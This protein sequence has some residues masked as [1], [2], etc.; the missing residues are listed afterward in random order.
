MADREQDLPREQTTDEVG[1]TAE[2]RPSAGARGWAR[3]SFW[4]LQCLGWAAYFVMVV[5]TFLPMLP[6]GASVWPLVRIKIVRTLIGFTLTSALRLVLRRIGAGR[7]GVAAAVAIP[8]A[9]LLGIV[10]RGL[11]GLV[12]GWQDDLGHIA[13]DW[14]RAPREA[15]DYALTVL[16]WSALYLGV[17]WARDLEA[18][19]AGALEA[20]ALAQQAQLDALRY[21]LNP[22]FLF[23][24]LNAIRALVDEDASR[25]RQMITALSEF[26]RYP[27]LGEHRTAV[28]LRE[29]LAAVRNYL[30]IEA[31]RFDGRLRVAIDADPALDDQLVPALVLHPLV[32][33]AVKHGMMSPGPLSVRVEARQDEA[34][35]V[36]RVTNTGVWRDRGST[37][38]TPGAAVGL[39]NVR[40]RLAALTPRP[41]ALT[42]EHDAG[43]V[44]VAVRLPHDHDAS[45]AGR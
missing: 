45:T 18:A 9:V 16:A 5:A 27:V 17:K 44:N 11:A 24:A 14:A 34:V 20:R 43:C 3:L 6:A 39:R 42:I 23:N 15:L 29:E 28:P 2:V 35:L 26:L 41:G 25:A 31:I 7:P 22:H 4:P 38:E 21:Q 40:A 36:L 33:N 32:E 19:H 12:H 10:W 8:S 30:D 37:L 13:I 1:V